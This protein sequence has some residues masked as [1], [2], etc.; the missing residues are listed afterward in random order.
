MVEEGH[1]GEEPGGGEGVGGFGAVMGE[2]FGADDLGAVFAAPI[3]AEDV[4]ED[5][6]GGTHGGSFEFRVSSFKMMRSA[7]LKLDT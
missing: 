5:E 4:S 7:V 1:G 3:A 2:A 6:V